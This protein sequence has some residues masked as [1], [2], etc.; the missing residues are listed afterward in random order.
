MMI[1]RTE[2]RGGGI[3]KLRDRDDDDDVWS[4][5]VEARLQDCWSVRSAVV[6]EKSPGIKS[7]TTTTTYPLPFINNHADYNTL[8]M[9]ASVILNDVAVFASR[10]EGLNLII[11]THGWAPV[12]ESSF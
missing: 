10:G 2:T 8:L 12:F 11:F 3:D 9:P 6:T 7:L 1:G 4:V 5:V